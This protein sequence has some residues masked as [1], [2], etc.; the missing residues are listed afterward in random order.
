MR[1][2]CTDN[3]KKVF[4]SIELSGANIT[5]YKLNDGIEITNAFINSARIYVR[6]PKISILHSDKIVRLYPNISDE[7]PYIDLLPYENQLV[8]LNCDLYENNKAELK[9]W[10]M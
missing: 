8:T 5:Y 3:F 9:L 7:G 6:E 4:S 2:L 1:I 10:L